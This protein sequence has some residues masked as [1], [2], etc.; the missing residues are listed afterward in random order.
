MNKQQRILAI[1]DIS[2]I[3]RCSLTV[4][5]PILSASG[6]DASVLPTA[7]LSTHT[8]GFS[9]FT[10]RDLTSDIEPIAE[11][12]HTLGMRFDGMYSGFLGSVEQV[13]MVASLFGQFGEG[14]TIMVDPV[15]AD[16]GELYSIFDESMVAGMRR[17]CGSA[18]I[19]VPNLTEASLLLDCPYVASGYDLKYIHNLAMQLSQLGASRVVVTG[20]SLSVGQLGAYCYDSA[21]GMG[22]YVHNAEVEGHYHGTGD[23]FGSAL[24]GALMC[25]KSLVD[26]TQIAVDYTLLCIEQCQLLG[27]ERRYGVPFERVLGSYIDM[28]SGK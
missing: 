19:I 6:C 20:V 27:Q 22:Q 14:G 21:S 16:N 25:G 11:H 1:H 7:V 13:D 12:W 4:A 28:L 24:L 5:L 3:G 10:Y 18:D 9:G 2:C 8:G 23:I 17:L 26:S 15:M